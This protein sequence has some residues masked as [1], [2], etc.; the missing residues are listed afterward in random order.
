MTCSGTIVSSFSTGAPFSAPEYFSQDTTIPGAHGALGQGFDTVGHGASLDLR[1]NI[2]VNGQGFFGAGHGAAVSAF[3]QGSTCLANRHPNGHGLD[4]VPELLQ[5]YKNMHVT[6]STN[7]T[8]INF[9]TFII[10]TPFT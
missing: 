5:P 3:G 6:A 2:A 7:K 10:I 4:A 1:E 9:L 8:K